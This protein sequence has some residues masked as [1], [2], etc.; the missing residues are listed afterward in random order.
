MAAAFASAGSAAAVTLHTHS[1]VR[2]RRASDGEHTELLSVAGLT[3]PY[4]F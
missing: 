4:A 2:Y 3:E 1:R